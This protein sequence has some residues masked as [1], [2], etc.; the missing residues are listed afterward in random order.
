MAK[1]N[2]KKFEV[3]CSKG[4]GK[5]VEEEVHSTNIYYNGS[6]QRFLKDEFNLAVCDMFLYP[7]KVAHLELIGDEWVLYKNLPE[8]YTLTPTYYI[9][10]ATDEQQ[11]F[12]NSLW[13]I[14]QKT[15]IH[16]H[17]RFD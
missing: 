9:K 16:L 6:I 13:F 8:V 3:F 4:P 5:G 1:D 10:G 7:A 2:K 11:K 17:I 12:V 14:N 15:Y